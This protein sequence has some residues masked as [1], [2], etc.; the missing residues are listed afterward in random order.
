M[1]AAAVRP[2]VPA[3]RAAD[4]AAADR[5]GVTRAQRRLRRRALQPRLAAAARVVPRVRWHAHRRLCDQRLR[6]VVRRLRRHLGAAARPSR[7]ARGVALVRLRPRRRC[8]AA[9]AARVAERRRQ[10]PILVVLLLDPARPPQLVRHRHLP[11]PRG[12]RA[13]G[14]S[15]AAPFPPL[16]RV[17]A[18]AAPL[19]RWSDV[20]RR[21]HGAW[22]VRRRARGA[23]AARPSPAAG[24]R[25]ARGA[26]GCAGDGTVGRSGGAG[27]APR[28]ERRQ[29]A[30][31]VDRPAPK[32]AQPRGGTA[33]A[34]PA[35][36]GRPRRAQGTR[37]LGQ[38][39]APF[40]QRAAPGAAERH[41]ATRQLK[42]VHDALAAGRHGAPRLD[43]LL[44]RPVDEHAVGVV[45]RPAA[46]AGATPLPPRVGALALG[47]PLSAAA[48]PTPRA[49]RRPLAERRRGRQRGAVRRRRPG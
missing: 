32:G 25:A 8:R 29:A 41:V 6:A 33:R 1:G 11:L 27:G 26:A 48:L 19:P 43:P 9:A 39:L 16:S 46:A 17:A 49:H 38:R 21:L 28:R 47:P 13:R 12:A 31:A 44:L 4:R 36:R 18:E 30:V 42:G 23:A 24:E 40:R 22:P 15:K 34:P 14:A 37:R 35:A 5:R 10:C 7:L 2:G 3:R 45:A 20:R